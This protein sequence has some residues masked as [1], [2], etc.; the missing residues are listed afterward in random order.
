MSKNEINKKIEQDLKNKLGKMSIV[1]KKYTYPMLTV[2]TNEFYRE[3]CVFLGDA[4]VGMHPI[5]AHGFNLNL[6]GVSILQNEIK[7]AI[8]FY[9][10]CNYSQY[11]SSLLKKKF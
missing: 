4:A 9:G 2:Y 7:N 5:T 8:K 6:R 3:R 11:L 1:G 10:K